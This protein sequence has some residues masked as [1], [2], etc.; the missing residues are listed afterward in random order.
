[1]IWDKKNNKLKAELNALKAWNELAIG[2]LKIK[3]EEVER[4]QIEKE[5]L[6]LHIRDLKDEIFKMQNEIDRLQEEL[7]EAGADGIL[8]ME[9]LSELKAK[10]TAEVHK[11]F[12]LVQKYEI[13]EEK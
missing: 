4:A 2:I 11:N 13:M 3:S 6:K 5:D 9:E 7:A 12:E 1:M 8:L 10:Y